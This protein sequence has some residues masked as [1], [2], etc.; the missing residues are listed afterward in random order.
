M[1]AF[2]LVAI[3]LLLVFVLPVCAEEEVKGDLTT[4][5]EWLVANGADSCQA[6]LEV[7]NGAVGV[8][9]LKIEFS[10][11]DTDYGSFDQIIVYTDTEGKAVS[12][13][14]VNH[15]SGTATLIATITD[16]SGSIPV[17]APKECTQKIDH[18]TPWMLSS[19]TVVD[20]T[21][22]GTVVPITVVYQDRWGN[23]IDNKRGAE[24]VSFMVGAPAGMRFSK[25][26]MT[27]LRL[28]Q[29]MRME[30]Q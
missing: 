27:L 11:L 14:K 28:S 22:V 3:I 17:I 6:I 26:P 21:T 15:K 10:L 4:S 20:E 29:S 1:R 13:F 18:D 16:P 30:R 12:T 23:L 9:G 25:G 24:T 8:Q 7:K 19:Y 2:G 5:K